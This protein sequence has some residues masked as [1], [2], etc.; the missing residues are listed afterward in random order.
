MTTNGRRWC[1]LSS[2]TK[3]VQ[4][5]TWAWTLGAERKK[6]TRRATGEVDYASTCLL[7][8]EFQNKVLSP[9]P[10]KNFFSLRFWYSY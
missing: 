3:M 8:S 10:Q 2:L 6:E 9:S 1:R 4:A 7:T 5:A